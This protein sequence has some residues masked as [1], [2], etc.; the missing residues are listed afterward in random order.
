LRN[1]PQARNNFIFS[2]IYTVFQIAVIVLY[3]IFMRPVA[4]TRIIDNGLFSAVGAAFLVL[5]GIF[6]FMDRL[7]IVL[8]LS[9]QNEMVWNRFHILNYCFSIPILFRG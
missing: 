5:I 6:I 4:Y 2:I 9:Q 1:S 3:A 7:W 8:L